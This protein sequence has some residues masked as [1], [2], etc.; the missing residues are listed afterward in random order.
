[1]VTK[2]N[3]VVVQLDCTKVDVE[4]I[5]NTNSLS[6]LC[7]LS[8]QIQDLLGGLIIQNNSGDNGL[9]LFRSKF[10]EV[11]ASSHRFVEA[12]IHVA[13][14]DDQLLSLCD[15]TPYSHGISDETFFV[16][17]EVDF[18]LSKVEAEF[19]NTHARCLINNVQA[20]CD[21]SSPDWRHWS[22]SRSGK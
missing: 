15:W 3:L 1:M 14:V 9:L 22:W 6:V 4:T 16:G 17:G 18:V 7:K 13:V 19:W 20:I 12:W 2:V 11:P 10:N 8:L 5:E 21:L